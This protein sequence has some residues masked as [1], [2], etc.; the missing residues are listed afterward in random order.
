ML[1]TVSHHNSFAGQR[2]KQYRV[3]LK[4]LQNQEDFLMLL[5]LLMDHIL[6]SELQKKIMHHTH[7]GINFMLLIYKLC[8][9]QI[10]YLRTVTQGML[11]QYTMREFLKI[12]H[13]LSILK[14]QMS[15]F[16]LT[17]IL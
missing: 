9:M 13:S 14:N 3:L 2:V 4:A 17:R 16:L 12:L 11:A 15:I 5:E 7:A 8:V 1:Y 10:Q 6:K